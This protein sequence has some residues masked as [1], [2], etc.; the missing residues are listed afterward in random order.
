MKK[1]I[2]VTIIAAFLTAILAPGITLQARES[3]SIR[4]KI[5]NLEHKYKE[6]LDLTSYIITPLEKETFFKLTNNRD[7][8]AF[9]VLFWNLRDPTDGTPDNEFKDEHIKRF[10]H[11]N[12]YFGFGTPIPGWKTDRGKFYILLGPPVAENEIFKSGLYPVLIWDYY[13]GTHNG[14]PTMFNIVFYKRRGAGDYKLYIPTV[15]GPASLLQTGIGQV[16]PFNYVEVYT[17]LKEIEP[18]V[19]DVAFTLV[20]GEDLTSLSPSLEAPL[21]LGRIYDLPKRK[22]N[23]TYAR[24][25]LNYKGIVETSVITDYIGVSSDVYVIRDPGLDINVAHFALRPERL[26]VD[27]S[28]DKDQF[29]FN[30]SL[31]V[32]VKKGEDVIMEYN[33]NYPFYYSKEDME[34]K[35]T[36]GIIITDYFPIIEGEY[37]VFMVLQNTV[38]KEISYFEKRIRTTEPSQT[39]PRVFGPFISYASTIGGRQ[40][41]AAFNIMGT[42]IKVDPKYTFGLKETLYTTLFI[43]RGNYDKT[44]RA[45]L[46]VTCADE[47]RPYS[48]T[49]SFDMPGGKKF[50]GFPLM[51][52]TLQYGNYTLTAK[53]LDEND[54]VLDSKE[55]MFM[56]SPMSSVPHP[57]SVSKVLKQD[58]YFLFYMMMADQYKNSKNTKKA[59]IYFEKAFKMQPSYPGLVKLYA[60]FLMEQKQYPRM[61]E[62]IENLK[63]ADKDA[64]DY[65][66]L[67]GR[68]LYE[69]KNYH[70]AVLAL[71]E[72]VKIYDSDMSVLNALGFSLIQTGDTGEARKVLS[73]SLV[74][75]PD[76]DTI[77]KA[78]KRMDSNEKN[79]K[80]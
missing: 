12:R 36:H 30:F 66:S 9:I 38:N 54:T 68:A 59:G 72:A 18:V 67:K 47:D 70:A 55:R 64:F 6:W 15:D 22:I 44:L 43:D 31:T 73:A 53:V 49:Y 24:N 2:F 46:D 26:S 27:Y 32:V 71:Q 28:P 3:K 33:K 40:G 80:K 11:A 45:Q 65:F 5:K 21:L 61:L 63:G 14:L 75:N 60:G 35:L 56:I 42:S 62:V 39:P 41:F 13:G 52:E 79:K 16:D 8:D 51:L 20:P 57:P 4:E 74:L 10:T 7:R 69:M 78:L 34:K 25:F 50:H 48:K 58:N 17:K 23:A 76:Q 37:D 1:K 29:Y 19:A 77:K